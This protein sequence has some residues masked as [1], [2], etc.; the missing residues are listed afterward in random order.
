[1]VFCSPPSIS[2]YYEQNFPLDEVSS[3]SVVNCPIYLVFEKIDC[4]DS[5]DSPGPFAPF[6]FNKHKEILSGT[7]LRVKLS[8]VYSSIPT[9]NICV[10]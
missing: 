10:K 6:P 1:M 9:P 7:Y 8:Q 5:I 2:P 3:I 4:C